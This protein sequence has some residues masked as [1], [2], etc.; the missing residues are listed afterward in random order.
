MTFGVAQACRLCGL[1][2]RNNY[3]FVTDIKSTHNFSLKKLGKRNTV[4]AHS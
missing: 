4:N 2:Y 3:K 1:I